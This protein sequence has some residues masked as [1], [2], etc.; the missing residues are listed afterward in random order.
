MSHLSHYVWNTTEYLSNTHEFPKFVSQFSDFR[1][2]IPS[3]FIYKCFKKKKEDCTNTKGG[4][5]GSTKNKNVS[6]K[7]VSIG[8]KGGAGK[9]N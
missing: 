1:G 6:I 8:L 7:I 9:V 4:D 3:V 5:E 2:G